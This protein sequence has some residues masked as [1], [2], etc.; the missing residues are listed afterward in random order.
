MQLK[1]GW[2]QHLEISKNSLT[3]LRTFK[4]KIMTKSYTLI[5]MSTSIYGYGRRLHIWWK[6]QK[7][8]CC[9]HFQ[10]KTRFSLLLGITSNGVMFPPMFAFTYKYTGKNERTFSKKYEKFKK[11]TKPCPIRFNDSDFTRQ[12]FIIEYIQ[13]PWFLI[14]HKEKKSSYSILLAHTRSKKWKTK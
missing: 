10:A 4:L 8:D 3:V 5:L 2:N 11:V 6:R 1:N 12:N 9:C 13:R 14:F 7:R